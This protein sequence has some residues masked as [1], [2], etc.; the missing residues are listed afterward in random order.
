M[1]FLF[2]DEQN[3][4]ADA[5]RELLVSECTT[6][7]LRAQM[8]SGAARD[9]QRWRRIAEMG[10]TAMLA[11]EDLGGLGLQPIDFVRIAEAA[12]YVALPEP[13]VEH[14]GVAVPLLASFAADERA[15]RL[16]EA[17]LRGDCT[18]SV[19]PAIN[20]FVADADTAAALLLERDGAVHLLAR[21]AVRLTRQDSVD[22]FRRLYRVDWTADAQTCLADAARGRELWHQ[23]LD[24]AALFGA[25]Q[26]LGIAQR[27]NDIATAYARERQQ[28]GRPIGANQAVKHQLATVQVKIE[29]ARPVLH[30]AA[31]QLPA[32]DAYSRARVSHARLAA[33]EAAELAARTAVQVHGAM[34]YS[35]EVDVHFFLKRALVL[36]QSWGTPAWHRARIAQRVYGRPLGPEHS[37]TLESVND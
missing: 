9:G 36:S 5:A 31:A 35:W 34:G 28:F 21:D 13:L 15:Q 4:M 14:A 23:A 18:V 22:P 20:P 26:C 37:F 6:A 19:G 27:C 8:Q 29:F 10:L 25:A 1:Q 12:G 17:A 2:T 3:L 7:Q 30:A 33:A 16:L 11:P 24:R 32:F